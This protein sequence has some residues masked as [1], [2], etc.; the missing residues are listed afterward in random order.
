MGL[1]SIILW[2]H[3]LCGMVWVGAS[4][5]FVIAAAALSGESSELSR[6]ATAAAP[7]IN[8]IGA[9]LA[10]VIPLTGI[11]NLVYAARAD[12]YVLP[13]EFVAIL[14]AK[15]T[16]FAAMAVAL[17]AAWRAENAMRAEAAVDSARAAANVG[18][19]M[20]LYGLIIAMG[21]VALGLG[22]WLSGT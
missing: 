16:L 15:I 1:R 19:L 10:L 11:G 12:R 22:V 9:I 18:K 20:R 8:R 3:A 13:P 17:A 14:V 7:R 5:S 21:A 6:F 2:I 4:A